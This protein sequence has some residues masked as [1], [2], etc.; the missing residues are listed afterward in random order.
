MAEKEKSPI[1][2]FGIIVLII[3][4]MVLVFLIICC[5]YFYNLMQL[6]P[7]S[8]G[9]ST[10]LFWT[11]L[12]M[13]VIFLGLIIYA[14]I[15][16]FTHKSIIYKKVCP[17]PQKIETTPVIVP[18]PVPQQVQAAPIRITNV[19]KQRPVAYSDVPVTNSQRTALNDEL[20]SLG[21]SISDA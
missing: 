16:I 21:G 5:V 11:A 4:V 3:A 15:H 6:K 13:A 7:P 12:I 8:K 19:P 20:I 2:I 18:Q 14:I 10:F 1:N 9:E 17:K